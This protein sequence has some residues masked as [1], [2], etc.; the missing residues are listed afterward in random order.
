MSWGQFVRHNRWQKLT[1]LFLA[2]LIWF[3]VNRKLRTGG[4]VRVTFDG[5]SRT[6]EGVPVR[7]LTPDGAFGKCEVRPATVTVT[8][9]GDPGLLNRLRV[10]QVRAFANLDARPGGEVRVPLQVIAPGLDLVEVSPR[11]V[12]I[13]PASPSPKEP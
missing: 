11:D 8:L 13:R 1:A 5:S 3:T 10:S 6:F 7:L 4:G 9:R 2:T 12:L